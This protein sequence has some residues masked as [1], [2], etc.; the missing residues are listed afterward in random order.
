MWIPGFE[1]R[2]ALRRTGLMPNEFF[3]EVYSFLRTSAGFSIK[4]VKEGINPVFALIRT[5]GQ[6]PEKIC[7]VD[8]IRLVLEDQ[9]KKKANMIKSTPNNDRCPMYDILRRDSNGR[10][11]VI[12]LPS[13]D[14][15]EVEK[16]AIGLAHDDP[17]S[18][19]IVTER[20]ME[21]TVPSGISIKRW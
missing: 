4:P 3:N 20:V 21:A 19:Y 12:G 2:Y 1:N 13:T 9:R 10:M 18:T 15:D 6:D 11:S 8:L 5:S 7:I 17:G 16:L 14:L